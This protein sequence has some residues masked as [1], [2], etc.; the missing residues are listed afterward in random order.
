VGQLNNKPKKI[1]SRRKF[2]ARA[3]TGIAG[4]IA[5]LYFGRS[6]IRRELSGFVAEM[7]MPSGISD[8]DPSL[9]FEINADNT[10]T[11]KSPKV[12]MGQGI[13]TGF[14]ML[15]AEEL[16]IALDKIKVV[17]ATSLNG[18]VASTGVS[19]STSTLYVNIREVAA[20][21]RETLKLEASKLWGVTIALISTKDGMLLAD[22]K[23]MTY[24]DLAKQA[25]QWEIAKTPPLR[26]ATSFKYVGKEQKRIDVLDKVL[27][28]PIYGIDTSLP[29]MVYGAV[30][31]SPYF[32]GKL[33]NTD[34]SSAKNTDGV[35]TIVED[36]EWI[37][38]IA[39]TRY[40]AETALSKVKAIWDYSPN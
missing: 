30:L 1:F 13:F 8:F 35:L 14:A 12:E 26:P 16:D 40:A 11:L 10:I 24:A 2:L 22:G 28:K 19:N 25:S 21:L 6:V 36:K 4:T 9:W 33:K 39:N 20:T 37:G 7:E 15:A 5:L 32:N 38:V 23:E 3:G 27:A 17:H 34:T 31:Y 29:N 18:I